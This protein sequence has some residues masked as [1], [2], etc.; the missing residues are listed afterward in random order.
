MSLFWHQDQQKLNVLLLN[1]M[2][3][4]MVFLSSDPTFEHFPPETVK[5]KYGKSMCGWLSGVAVVATVLK[6]EDG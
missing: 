1:I 2:F 5:F 3:L 4:V 6:I